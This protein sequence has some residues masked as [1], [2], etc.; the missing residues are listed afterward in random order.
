MTRLVL[1]SCQIVCQNQIFM[2]ITANSLSRSHLSSLLFIA[3][4]QRKQAQRPETKITRLILT[5]SHTL[6]E[7]FI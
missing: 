2:E 1:C 6:V 4:Q 5:A 3:A 7:A